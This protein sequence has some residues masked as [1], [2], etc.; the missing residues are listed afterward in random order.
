MTLLDPSQDGGAGQD[1][2]L[3]RRRLLQADAEGAESQL[4]KSE[5]AYQMGVVDEEGRDEMKAVAAQ[6]IKLIQQGHWDE[7]RKLSKDECGGPISPAD[8][9]LDALSNYLLWNGTQDNGYKDLA[10]HQHIRKALHV[11]NATFSLV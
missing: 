11:G 4:D 8:T 7:A 5:V 3:R 10:Q 2:L 1:A 9:G 6:Q